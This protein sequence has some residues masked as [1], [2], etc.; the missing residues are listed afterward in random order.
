MMR[1][2][3]ESN[4]V[5]SSFM[6]NV[7]L[8]RYLLFPNCLIKIIEDRPLVGFHFNNHVGKAQYTTSVIDNIIVN[9]LFSWHLIIDN[10]YKDNSY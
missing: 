7:W 2:E 8:F 3:L 10:K 6:Q 1:K 4:Q 9:I 5:L